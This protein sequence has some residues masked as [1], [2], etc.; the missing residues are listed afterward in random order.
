VLSSP[1]FIEGFWDD[2]IVAAM[3]AIYRSFS[4]SIWA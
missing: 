2:M 3:A 1:M 4:F